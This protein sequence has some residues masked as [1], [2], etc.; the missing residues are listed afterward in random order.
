MALSQKC[1]K[2]QGIC[3]GSEIYDRYCWIII[4]YLKALLSLY[5]I[6]KELFELLCVSI[7]RVEIHVLA[8]QAVINIKHAH[9]IAVFTYSTKNA[10]H[11]VFTLAKVSVANL[12]IK[13]KFRVLDWNRNIENITDVY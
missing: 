12:L 2:L 13:V 4:N 9:G 8:A 7:S 6:N 5:I 3:A 10:T 11:F 1:F